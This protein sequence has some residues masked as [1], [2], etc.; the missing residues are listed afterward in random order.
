MKERVDLFLVALQCR[1]RPMG[2]CYMEIDSSSTDR[3][4]EDGLP[5]WVV[6]SPSLKVLNQR[7][8][9]NLVESLLW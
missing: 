1:V 4:L 7:L 6:S 3:V 5:Q 8:E 2:E 9:N